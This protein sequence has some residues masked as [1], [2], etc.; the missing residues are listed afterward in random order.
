M[1]K[2]SCLRHIIPMRMAGS[3]RRVLAALLLLCASGLVAHVLGDEEADAAGP[4]LVKVRS[5]AASTTER[6]CTLRGRRARPQAGAPAPELSRP[7]RRRRRRVHLACVCAV[8]ADVG[9]CAWAGSH[10]QHV[11]A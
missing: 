8:C 11:R 10:G 3:S 6:A 2:S 5:H 9:A 4:S 1:G 7:V